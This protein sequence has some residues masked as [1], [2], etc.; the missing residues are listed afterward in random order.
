MSVCRAG[1]DQCWHSSCAQQQQL[2]VLPVLLPCHC[3][4]AL[5]P[6]VLLQGLSALGAGH[7]PGGGSAGAAA[8]TGHGHCW[9]SADASGQGLGAR[10]SLARLSPEHLAR[11]MLSRENPQ[12]EQPQ[13]GRGQAGDK[14]HGWC[15]A[16][17]LQGADPG[18]EQQSRG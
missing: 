11:P 16:R 18:K 10:G 6:L 17:S 7:S 2:L 12:G 5:L 1:A 9:G 3:P 15:S 14:Q 8:G 13:A 4:A